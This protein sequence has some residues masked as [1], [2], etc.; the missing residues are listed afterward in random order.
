MQ[1]IGQNWIWI[2]LIVA[3]VAFHLFG[4]RRNRHGSLGGGDHSHGGIEGLGGFGHDNHGHAGH[5]DEMQ[6]GL[7]SQAVEAAIDPVGGSTI[8]TA[9]AVTSVYQGKAYY[10]ASK[11]NRDRF[12]AAPQDF[13][14]KALGVPIERENMDRPRHRHGGC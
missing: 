9:G 3:F 14:A 6:S 7:G 1:N 8:S 11:E 4:H 2:V 5:G 13:A 10:F 12:E